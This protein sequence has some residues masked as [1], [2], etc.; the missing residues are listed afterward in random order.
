MKIEICDLLCYVSTA[1]DS[2]ENDTIISTCLAFY[3]PAKIKDAKL[4]LGKILNEEIKWRR[5]EDRI[6]GDAQDIIDMLNGAY[7]KGTEIPKFVAEKYNSLPPSNGFD[8]IGETLL[9][10]TDQISNLNS[11]INEL[12]TARINEISYK[13]EIK[14]IKN[15]IVDLKDKSLQNRDNVD[16]NKIKF[17]ENSTPTAPTELQIYEDEYITL[18]DEIENGRSPLRIENPL[19]EKVL[20]QSKSW[21][22]VAKMKAPKNSYDKNRFMQSNT[23]TINSSRSK[24]NNVTYD[25]NYKRKNNVF[26]NKQVDTNSKFKSA[27]SFVDVYLGRCDLQ[28][29]KEDILSYLKN[30]LNIDECKVFDLESKN[31]NAKSFKININ[32]SMRDKL[33]LEDSWPSGIICRKFYSSSKKEQ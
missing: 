1:L 31:P 32:I 4:K 10:L 27:K 19:P 12:K 22:D 8:I 25:R 28:V 33:L 9:R 18:N 23:K 30:E 26:G 20:N 13:E 7:L 5:G 15:L 21:A 14:H 16:I 11:E 29:E 3:G 17:R 2:I 6:K 24:S